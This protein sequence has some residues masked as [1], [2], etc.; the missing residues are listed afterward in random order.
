MASDRW[1]QLD[2][3]QTTIT[4]S[5]GYRHSV[6]VSVTRDG[7]VWLRLGRDY[8][9]F[10]WSLVAQRR[11]RLQAFVLDDDMIDTLHDV[12]FIDFCVLTDLHF[13]LNVDGGWHPSYVTVYEPKTR[14]TRILSLK[15][16]RD[17]KVRASLRLTAEKQGFRCSGPEEISVCGLR[18]VP[19]RG[20]ASPTWFIKYVNL[21]LS[22]PDHWY[23]TGHE[24][25]NF[26]TFSGSFYYAFVKLANCDK[27]EGT[28]PSF[29]ITCSLIRILNCFKY[30]RPMTIII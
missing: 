18:N 19:H 23:C 29:S 28:H 16:H 30:Y 17:C 27:P 1:C 9:A 2:S 3:G 26:Y 6:R 4:D 15:N 25:N 12:P 22:N 5:Q 14:E 20:Q 10:D 21:D 7:S 24:E 13:E 11:T 8:E